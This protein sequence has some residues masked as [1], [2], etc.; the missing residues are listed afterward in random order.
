MD[1]VDA[2]MELE[3]GEEIPAKRVLELYSVIVKSG[4]WRGLQGSYTSAIGHLIDSGWLDQE[5]NILKEV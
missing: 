1:I 2:V 5:G 3:S 4:G